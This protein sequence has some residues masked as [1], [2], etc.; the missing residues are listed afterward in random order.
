MN[1][2]LALVALL[3]LVA[4][5][6][7]AAD[8]AKTDAKAEKVVAGKEEAAKEGEKAADAAPAAGEAKKEEAKH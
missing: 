2:T 7:F 8:A 1:K 4:T 3:G 5:P 6:V